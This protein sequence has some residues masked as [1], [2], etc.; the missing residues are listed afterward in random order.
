MS[1]PVAA[2]HEHG[3]VYPDDPLYSRITA[4]K[5]GMWIFLLSDGFSFGGLLLSYGILRGGSDYWGCTTDAIAQK[6]GCVLEPHLGVPFTALLT[7]IL[8]CSSVTMVLAHAAAVDGDRRGTMKWLA[9]TILGGLMFLCGQVWE[10]WGWWIPHHGLLHEGL[11]FGAS[12]YATTFYAITG[13]HG[14]HVT[15]GVIY[16]STVLAGTALGK[17]DANTIEVVGLFWHF[18]DLVWILVF[19]FVY[20]I[21]A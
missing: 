5:V 21:P 8:I 3:I 1:A 11:N 4:G 15:T 17:T 16:L 14:M 18:V 2:D 13:F 9:L 19:T 10:Y 6:F 7:F 12:H 20:L